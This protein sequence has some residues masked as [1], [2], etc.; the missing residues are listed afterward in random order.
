MSKA[1]VVWGVNGFRPEAGGVHSQ[2]REIVAAKS[3]AA[4]GRAFRASGLH[5]MTDSHLAGWGSPTGNSKELGLA[6]AEPGRVFWAPLGGPERDKYRRAEL[7]VNWTA[8]DKTASEL[9]SGQQV[10]VLPKKGRAFKAMLAKPIGTDGCRWLVKKDANGKFSQVE[11]GQIF[12]I[13]AK[14]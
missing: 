9:A 2:T 10:K 12:D 3:R 11:C 4:A 14:L 8:V 5:N 13:N 1:L 7:P 6:L